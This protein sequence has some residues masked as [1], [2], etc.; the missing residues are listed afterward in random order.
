MTLDE[1]NR[2]NK[3][4]VGTHHVIKD[5]CNEGD[6]QEQFLRH[7]PCLRLVKSEYDICAEK[8]QEIMSLFHDEKNNT[9]NLTE[10]FTIKTVCW[11]VK[12]KLFLEIL[13]FF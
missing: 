3:L 13:F 6:F 12:K 7:A 1:R 9:Q 10:D 8:Y 5:I 11:Y 4:Y 2:F